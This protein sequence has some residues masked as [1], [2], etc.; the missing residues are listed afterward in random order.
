MFCDQATTHQYLLIQLPGLMRK[1]SG[2]IAL[3]CLL[4]IIAFSQVG[5]NTNGNP[6]DPSAGLDVSFTDK[7]FLPPRVALTAVNVAAPVS[8]PAVGLIVFNTAVA[9]TSPDNVTVG[10]YYWNGTKWITLATPQGTS[11]GDMQYWNGSQWVILPAGSNGKIMIFSDGVPRW[12][13]PSFA[14]GI[15][16]TVNHV[17]GEVCPVSKTVTYGTVTNVP[18]ETTK[19]WITKNLGADIQAPSLNDVSEAAAGWYWQ[20]NLKR[21]F[22]HDGSTRTPNTTWVSTLNE[23]SNWTSA[24]DPCNIEIGNGWRMP[25]PSEWTNVDASGSWTNYNG[26][27]NSLLKLHPAGYVNYM[28]GSLVASGSAGYYWSSGQSDN[29]YSQSMGF[30]SNVSYVN[31]NFNKAYG[32]SIRCIRNN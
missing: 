15:A 13:V 18:G 6:P 3:F 9:G 11:Y 2:L 24:N 31:T 10:Y 4:S 14:C 20:F 28:N 25:T 19:C 32:A 8:S 17:A 16:F 29:S 5:V 27:W 26:P 21:G 30:S 1:S 7:G 22:K 12:A 23:N